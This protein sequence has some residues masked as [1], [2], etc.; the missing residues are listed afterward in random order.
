MLNYRVD[1]FAEAGSFVVEQRGSLVTATLVQPHKPFDLAKYAH[2]PEADM[3]AVIL[4]YKDHFPLFEQLLQ[5]IVAA[6]FASDG[7]EACFWM[8]AVSSFG[9]NFL[10]DGIFGRGLDNGGGGY[11]YAAKFESDNG[12]SQRNTIPHQSRGVCC[13]VDPVL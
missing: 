5:L 9:K 1:M 6:R 12:C 8:Q 3:D 10:A 11:L 7:R 4:D 2:V 13:S